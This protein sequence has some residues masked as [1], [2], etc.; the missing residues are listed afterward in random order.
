MD[1]AALQ[2]APVHT[3]SRSQPFAVGSTAG[4]QSS[5][6]L[7]IAAV[8]CAPVDGGL[9]VSSGQAA[10]ALGQETGHR[11]RQ[12][13]YPNEWFPTPIQPVV[14]ESA[15]LRC[16]EFR[17]HSEATVFTAIPHFA[18]VIILAKCRYPFEYSASLAKLP[19]Q[20]RSAHFPRRTPPRQT[21]ATARD[22]GPAATLPARDPSVLLAAAGADREP[23]PQR[24]PNGPPAEAQ[25][26]PAGDHSALARPGG[27][28]TTGRHPLR[29]IIRRSRRSPAPPRRARSGAH[30]PC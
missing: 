27:S 3:G 13:A 6:L 11:G 22:P 8:A 16:S 17:F 12:F 9:K 10:R 5:A 1:T 25:P 19:A 28:G 24:P 23:I 14:P 7:C 18:S 29:G 4:S 21:L 15:H 20:P 30:R 2:R 26:L